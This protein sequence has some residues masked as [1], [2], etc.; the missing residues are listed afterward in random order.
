VQQTRT[1]LAAEIENA[2]GSLRSAMYQEKANGDA[3]VA[4]FRNSIAALESKRNEVTAQLQS[5]SDEWSHKAA[6]LLASQTRELESRR[7]EFA[8]L[9]QAASTEW[10]RRAESMLAA[11]SAEMDRRA[12]SAVTGMAQRLQPLLESAGH[13]TIEKLAGELEQRI[14]P[15]IAGAMDILNQ[16]TFNRDEAD[17][18]VATHQQRIFHA[19]DRSLQDTAAR[20]KELLAQIEKEFSESAGSVSARWLAEIE[21]RATDTSHSTFESLYKSADWYEKKIQAQMQSTLEKGIDLATSRLRKRPR[22]CPDCSPANWSTTAA[23]TWNTPAARCTSTR[24]TPRRSAAGKFRKLAIWQHPS[25]PSAPRSWARN[26]STLTRR[27][28]NRLSSRAPLRWRRMWHK[29]A[30]NWKATRETSPRNSR[31]LCRNMASRR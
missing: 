10:G 31:R 16:L 27:K 2:L 8:S 15:Q 9:L 17:K 1:Q 19:S 23:A 24:A 20:G 26:N 28:R 21:T 18:A 11:Q 6:D 5:A 7:N 25:S 13:D 29:S 22:K 4:Q 14:S 12:E 30:R 3:V